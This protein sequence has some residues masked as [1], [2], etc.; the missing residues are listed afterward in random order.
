QTGT[1]WRSLIWLASTQRADGCMPQNSWINGDAYWQGKQLD[2]VAAPVLLAWKLRQS[3]ALGLFDPWPMI[4]RAARY[5]I[6]NG[7]VTGQERWEESSGYSPS[8]LAAIIAALICAAEF[9]RS[10]ERT[11]S[12]QRK[13]S[14][15]DGLVSFILDYADWLSAHLEEWLVTTCG[16]L[17]PGKPRHYIRINPADPAQ[18]G[19]IPNPNTAQLQIS[20]GGGQ[21]PASNIV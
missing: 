6:L 15:S 8:T 5:L 18:P 4:S 21:Y 2:E 7:P 3:N 1:P 14:S 13:P 11:A 19:M 17:L 9:A 12:V 20:N 16:E 10:S